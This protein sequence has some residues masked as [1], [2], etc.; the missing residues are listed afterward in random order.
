[1]LGKI[2]KLEI[3]ETETFPAEDVETFFKVFVWTTGCSSPDWGAGPH[4]GSRSKERLPDFPRALG[5]RFSTGRGGDESAAKKKKGPLSQ[6]LDL[7]E[8]DSAFVRFTGRMF[9]G[10]SC[11]L[12]GEASSY[13]RF[14]LRALLIL[15]HR[16]P[17]GIR[18]NPDL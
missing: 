11:R 15:P 3:F 16:A 9:G 1:V 17:T 6:A 18:E 7:R 2:A 5:Q 10:S 12:L 4:S 13:L 8:V 14:V